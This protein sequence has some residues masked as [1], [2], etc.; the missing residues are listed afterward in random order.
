[1]AKEHVK[2]CINENGWISQSNDEF[3]EELDNMRKLNIE[4]EANIKTC[5]G[6]YET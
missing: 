4:I 5:V 6:M 1:M 3:C 2:I